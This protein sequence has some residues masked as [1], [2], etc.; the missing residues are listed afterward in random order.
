MWGICCVLC[1]GGSAHADDHLVA[2]PFN[3]TWAHI[4][5][6]DDRAALEAIYQEWGIAYDFENITWLENDNRPP[7]VGLT[8]WEYESVY[9]RMDP[10]DPA[11]DVLLGYEITVH[12]RVIGNHAGDPPAK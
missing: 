5:D 10:D 12:A 11:D 4:L 9:D 2:E 7:R 3:F 6:S 1:L 8:D